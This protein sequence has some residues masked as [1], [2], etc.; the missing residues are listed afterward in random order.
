MHHSA[1]FGVSASVSKTMNKRKTVVG[2]PYWMAPEVISA[3]DTDVAYN[4]RVRTSVQTTP[5]SDSLFRYKP[6]PHMP[7]SRS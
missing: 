4:E 5:R 3:E 1:D 2:S 7:F 6:D